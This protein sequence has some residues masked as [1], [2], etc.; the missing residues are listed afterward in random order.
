MD[1]GNLFA[2][3]GWNNISR[4]KLQKLSGLSDYDMQRLYAEE[5]ISNKNLLKICLALNL[6]PNDISEDITISMNELSAAVKSE[7]NMHRK[8]KTK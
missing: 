2:Y 3:M 6:T 8:Y 4:D 1:Y 5:K 7:S